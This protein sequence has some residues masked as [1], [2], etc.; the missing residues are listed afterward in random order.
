MTLIEPSSRA[1][2]GKLKSDCLKRDGYRCVV[3]ESWDRKWARDHRSQVP[4]GEIP[5]HT[6]CA[7][8]LPFALAD[9]DE[10]RSVD[11]QNKAIIWDALH[12]Y[13][14]ALK[15]IIRSDT[16]NS[17]ENAMTLSLTMHKSFGGFEI[18]F[19]RTVSY[20]HGILSLYYRSVMLMEKLEQSSHLPD[21]G[22]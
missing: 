8:I 13:F 16:I 22:T 14:P 1:G 7:H 3:T 20:H 9:F 19:E 12:R 10:E 18:S 4:K 11:V 15:G 5:E 21:C 6:E 2:Q 17:P